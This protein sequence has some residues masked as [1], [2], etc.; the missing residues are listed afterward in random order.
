MFA[1]C[2][3]DRGRSVAPHSVSGQRNSVEIGW[4]RPPPARISVPAPMK[5][6]DSQAQISSNVRFGSRLCENLVD[7]MI[8]LLNRRGK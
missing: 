6:T 5:A 7:A 2:L 8:L 1:Y 3:T 4:A